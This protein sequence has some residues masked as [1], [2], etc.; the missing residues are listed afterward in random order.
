MTERLR[1]VLIANR[2]EIAVR[3][4]RACDALGIESVAVAA[5][6]DEWSLHTRVATQWR[7]IG[8]PG[9]TVA[10]YLDVDALIAVAL[11]TGCDGVHPGYGFV[12]ESAAFAERCAVAGLTFVGPSAATLALFGDKVRAREV[13]A[14]LGIPVLAGS[15]GA[16]TSADDA[17]AAA[18][19]AR[20]SGDGQGGGRRRWSR[21]ARRRRP[22]RH[23]RGVRAVSQ[24]G[25]RRLR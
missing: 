7:T 18:A 10:A 25:E 19:D 13:A 2:G 14:S 24:R 5:A 9:D 15:A 11:E 8:S 6:V 12:A 16:V 22:G 21:P 4:A 23:G 20:L 17:A 3:I 1:R